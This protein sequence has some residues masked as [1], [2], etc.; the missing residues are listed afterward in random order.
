MIELS[1]LCD[2]EMNSLFVM[3]GFSTIFSLTYQLGG[4]QIWVPHNQTLLPIQIILTLTKAMRL[5]F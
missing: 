1:L 4:R 2:S 3:R 5:R